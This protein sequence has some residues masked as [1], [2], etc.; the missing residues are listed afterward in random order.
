M[1]KFFKNQNRGSKS[2][3]N[4]NE[5]DE[6]SNNIETKSHLDSSNKNKNVIKEEHSNMKPLAFQPQYVYTFS[7][8]QDKVLYTFGDSSIPIQGSQ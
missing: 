6:E 3:T 7:K 4:F 2:V 5:Q 8:K 1:N